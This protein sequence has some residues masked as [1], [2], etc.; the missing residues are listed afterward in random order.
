MANSVSGTF[1]VTSHFE[2][3]DRGGFVIGHIKSGSVAVGMYV[4]TGSQPPT[5]KVSGVEFVDNVSE[6]KYWN[7][8]LFAERPKLD[9]VER[10]FPVGFK[11]E[12]V[13]RDDTAE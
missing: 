3:K 2:L 11:I 10:V 7:A 4:N 12:V 1:E 13:S 6:K 8:L 5:L 9:F